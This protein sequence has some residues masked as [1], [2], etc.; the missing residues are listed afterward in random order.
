MN[1]IIGHKKLFITL[2][3]FLGALIVFIIKVATYDDY[4]RFS[5]SKLLRYMNNLIYLLGAGILK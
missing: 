3:I 1:F 4:I 2:L 5:R